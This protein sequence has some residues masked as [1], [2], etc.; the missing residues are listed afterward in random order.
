MY[1][2][3][4]LPEFLEGR[5]SRHR[6]LEYLTYSTHLSGH[7]KQKKMFPIKQHIFK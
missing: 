2:H 1:V 3:T 5:A 6:K 7:V 4:L